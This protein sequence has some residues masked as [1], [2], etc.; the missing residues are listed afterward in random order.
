[1]IFKTVNSS[2]EKTQ[3]KIDIKNIDLA[4]EHWG[5]E[6]QVCDWLDYI[7]TLSYD[8][9]TFDKN[10]VLHAID[11]MKGNRRVK[12]MVFYRIPEEGKI[13]LLAITE[14]KKFKEVNAFDREMGIIFKK[15]KFAFSIVELLED[16]DK[17]VQ[18]G[19]KSI[20]KN[21]VIDQKLTDRFNKLKDYQF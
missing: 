11:L 5:S 2:I 13:I 3:Y 16:E 19:T 4:S 21:W 20:P 9:D 1:M 18:A 6:K 10:I 15:Q 17:E 14:V 12:D 8:K 7:E